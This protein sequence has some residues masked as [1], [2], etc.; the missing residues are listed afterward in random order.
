MELSTR[1]YK[2][3]L[4]KKESFLISSL[5][6]E[7]KN[8]FTIEDARQIVKDNTKK[9]MHS[10]MEKKWLL[11]LK[12]GL[13]A[14]VPLDI[15]IRGA[16]SFVMHDFVIASYL[17]EPYY[18]AFW[19][20][21]N[22]HGFSDQIPRTVFIASTKARKSLN[23]LNST[24]QFIK[25]D[26]KKFFGVT[27]TEIEERTIYI[28]D[29][30]KTVAD[31]LDHPEHSGGIDEIAR[32]IFFSHKELE[33]TSVKEYAYGMNNLTIIKRLGYILEKTELLQMYIAIFKDFEPSK[34]YPALDPISPRK[35]KYNTKWGLLINWDLK[36]EGWMY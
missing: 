9:I 28:S 35:G 18:I 32:S 23:I 29:P 3:G 20:A 33:F 6:R 21:L 1:T 13:Y 24:Y 25:L 17:T 19:S 12:R 5:A 2:Q 27:T 14:I 36:P 8:V 31:C 15:G 10:L 7:N 34:G 30:E 11:P 22:Y 26:E 4:S 16:D